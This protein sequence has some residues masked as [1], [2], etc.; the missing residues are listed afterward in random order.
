MAENNTRHHLVQKQRARAK[1][2]AKLYRSDTAKHLKA[3]LLGG[4]PAGASGGSLNPNVE[5]ALNGG[6]PARPETLVFAAYLAANATATADRFQDMCF[7]YSSE[8]SNPIDTFAT[9]IQ[10]LVSKTSSFIEMMMRWSTPAGIARLENMTQDFVTSAAD[11]VLHTIQEQVQRLVDST[12]ARVIDGLE[13]GSGGPLDRAADAIEAAA[14]PV[15]DA[16]DGVLNMTRGILGEGSTAVIDGVVDQLQSTLDEVVNGLRQGVVPGMGALGAISIPSDG[17]PSLLELE[18]PAEEVEDQD[19]LDDSG[20]TGGMNPAIMNVVNMMRSLGNL[21]PTATRTLVLAQ[22]EVSRASSVMDSL[23]AMLGDT[24]PGIF[25]NIALLW[26]ILWIGYFFLMAPLTGVILYY[27]FWAGGFCGGP[28][29]ISDTGEENYVPPRTC[30]QRL[31]VCCTSWCL[32][33]QQCHDTQLCIW[34]A[35][36]FMELI[37]LII[38]VI[39]IVLCI[40]AGVKAFITAGCSQVYLLSDPTICANTVGGIRN[41]LSSYFVSDALENLDEI[42]PSN[43]LMTCQLIASRM[44]TSVILTTVFSFAAV[45]FSMQILIESAVL[46]EHARFRRM[47]TERQLEREELEKDRRRQELLEGS[48]AMA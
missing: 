9:Q 45:I 37:V 5:E 21:V 10:S 47:F 20:A 23:F 24:A 7:E 46:H 6:Q 22:G 35:I 48:S 19:D 44:K 14:G 43:S 40:L 38:F 36:L 15:E 34:S 18:Q 25:D 12:V 8:S 2:N 27:G 26:R 41:W 16:V 33:C 28:Q 31:R 1:S 42:C 4:Q 3:K 11:Q 39:S 13:P 29:P 32:C 30:W 17:T